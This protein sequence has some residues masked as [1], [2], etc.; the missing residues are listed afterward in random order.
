[1]FPKFTVPGPVLVTVRLPPV[2]VSWVTF[3]VNDA[4]PNVQ[5]PPARRSEKVT[6][7]VPDPPTNAATVLV[8]WAEIRIGADPF[9]T[10]LGV[11]VEPAVPTDRMFDVDAAAIVTCSVPV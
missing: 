7:P 3:T 10:M 5:F 11:P 9:C 8:T 1:M 4:A 2:R 6:V